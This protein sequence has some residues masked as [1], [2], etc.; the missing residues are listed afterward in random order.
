MN[1]R[2]PHQHSREDVQSELQTFVGVGHKVADC[3]ALFSLDRQDIIPVDTHVW[4]IACRDLDPELIHQK[5]LTPAVY[6]RVGELFRNKFGVYAGWAHS[7]L[8]AAELPNFSKLLPQNMQ[9]EMS[10][11]KEEEKQRKAIKRA[12]A[13]ERKELK[14]GSLK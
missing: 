12:E 9:D 11:F 5:S 3:V 6:H 10:S 13:K 4:Q 1:L 8:F 2:N 14:K 7:L